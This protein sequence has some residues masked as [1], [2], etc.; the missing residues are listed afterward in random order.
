MSRN[1]GRV[2]FS[3]PVQELAMKKVAKYS[4]II[5]LLHDSILHGVHI[6]EVRLDSESV[7]C[8]LNDSY[9]V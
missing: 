3:P 6:L 4:V 5:E 1:N 8:Q 9:H 2:M 7:V